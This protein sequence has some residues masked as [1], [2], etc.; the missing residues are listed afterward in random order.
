[1]RQRVLIRRSKDGI[2]TTFAVYHLAVFLITRLLYDLIRKNGRIITTG[3]MIHAQ[4]IDFDNLR[5]EKRYDPQEAYARSKLFNVLFL[6]KLAA[7]TDRSGISVNCFHLGVIDTKLLRKSLGGGGA[8]VSE[9]AASEC[10]VPCHER[11]AP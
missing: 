4:H 10:I 7:M 6:Y 11:R 9:G 3:S 2:E 1:V 5:G 8:P